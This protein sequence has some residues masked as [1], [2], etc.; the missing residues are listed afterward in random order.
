MHPESF[1]EPR[2]QSGRPV[3]PFVG[4]FRVEVVQYVRAKH[5]GLVRVPLHF[6]QCYWPVGDAS[7]VPTYGVTGILPPLVAQALPAAV[8]IFE[9]TVTVAIAIVA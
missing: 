4:T 8:K 5:R 1:V 3:T 6:A 7:I 9:K 2:L